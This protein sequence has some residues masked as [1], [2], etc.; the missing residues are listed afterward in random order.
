M[1]ARIAQA[2]S[3]NLALCPLIPGRTQDLCPPNCRGCAAADNR[4]SRAS[5]LSAVCPRV[6]QRLKYTCSGQCPGCY[7]PQ[8]MTALS[9]FSPA[10]A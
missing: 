7:A 10:R 2:E 5:D 3:A 6:P 9:G 1:T 4:Q 8:E